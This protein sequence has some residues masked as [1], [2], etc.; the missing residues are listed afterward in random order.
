MCKCPLWFA[1]CSCYI[2]HKATIC[3]FP[4]VASLSGQL[5][6]LKEATAQREEE[7]CCVRAEFDKYK[8]RAQSVLKKQQSVHQSAAELEAVQRADLLTQQSE[9]LRAQL[10]QAL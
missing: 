1:L 8:V 9:A 3:L 4:Q 2:S 7:L 5:A 10:D 6:S